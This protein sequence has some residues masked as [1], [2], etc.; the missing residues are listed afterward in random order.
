MCSLR[1]RDTN[2]HRER[3]NP[4]NGK[5]EKYRYML[6]RRLTQTSS[7]HTD[8]VELFWQRATEEVFAEF[9]QKRK[10]LICVVTSE[11]FFLQKPC[12]PA[13]ARLRDCPW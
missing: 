1:K 12:V 5:G 3:R 6:E 9:L 4:G 11:D 8:M 10:P 13:A 7:V 2:L